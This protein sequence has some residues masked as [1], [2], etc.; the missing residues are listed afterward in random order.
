M[1]ESAHQTERGTCGGP[2]PAPAVVLF[3]L[4]WFAIGYWHQRRFDLPTPVSRL[5]Q[6]HAWV[7]QGTWN[8]DAYFGNTGDRAFYGGHFY[9]DKARGTVA[10]LFPA[11]LV[12]V[13]LAE[14]TDAGVETRE[15]WLM[16]SW[17]A[18]AGAVAPLVAAGGV[19]F[20][21]WLSRF[22]SERT[23]LLGTLGL[24]LGA[25]PLPYSTILYSHALVIG[26]L[27]TS[28]YSFQRHVEMCSAR[29]SIGEEPG[30]PSA[31]EA[32]P[33]KVAHSW[34]RSRWVWLSGLA[35]GWAAVSE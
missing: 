1:T 29:A 17:S 32:R 24:F 10:V 15:G 28:L 34:S 30:S 11:F 5:D 7:V 19:A 6:L 20:W 13:A 4:L 18:C 16:T 33:P 25:A 31:S 8:I 22:V 27:A 12:G 3:L 23:A 35:A 9:S 2:G 26:L 14:W 21:R